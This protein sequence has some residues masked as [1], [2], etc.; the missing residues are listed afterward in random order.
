[1]GVGVFQAPR[2][3]KTVKLSKLHLVST[4]IMSCD[5]KY[6]L[7]PCLLLAFTAHGCL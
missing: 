5:C 6:L 3:R 4:K 1:M 2:G 7:W